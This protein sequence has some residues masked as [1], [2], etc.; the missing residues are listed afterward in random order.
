M[1]T[2]NLRSFLWFTTGVAL[3]MT[4]VATF[5]AWRADAAVTSGE[6]TFVPIT[7]CRLFDTRPA[8]AIPG[9]NTTPFGPTETRTQQVSGN[10]GKCNLPAGISGV[11]MN[12]TSLNGTAHSF[13][14]AY[15]ADAAALP[16]A[17]NLVWSPGQSATPN[18][19]DVKVSTA[20]KAKIYNNAGQVDVV[21]DVVGYYQSSSVADLETRLVAAETALATQQDDVASLLDN[22]N[23]IPSGVTVSS[24]ELFLETFGDDVPF[25]LGEITLP[26]TADIRGIEFGAGVAPFGAAAPECSGSDSV[27]TAA[28]GFLCIYVD[29]IVNVGDISIDTD[30]LD[31]RRDFYIKMEPAPGT[32]I[33]D[34]IAVSLSWAFTAP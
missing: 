20:G 24:G 18:K 33:G 10:V 16:L 13:L 12:M 7:P 11:A 15:P 6:S 21:A 17:A 22:T 25:A 31:P 9:S 4:S 26:G 3:T 32:S 19:V 34:A 29:E 28:P 2:L 30:P 1:H 14:V 23:V 27:P 5:G 8:E